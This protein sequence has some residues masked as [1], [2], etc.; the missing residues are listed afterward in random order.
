MERELSRCEQN[1]DY[2][3]LL[4]EIA[5][6]MNVS[7]SQLENYPRDMQMF[8]CQT[9]INNYQLDKEAA[10]LALCNVINL[11]I[12]SEPQNPKKENLLQKTS[13]ERQDKLL[14]A[15]DEWNNEKRTFHISRKQ[16]LHN[17][18]VISDN[19]TNPNRNVQEKIQETEQI[20]KGKNT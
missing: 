13:Q 11:N 2:D 12:P 6:L 1:S 5:E 4:P 3:R 9:Y 18:K 17:A 10:K 7:V 14:P 19:Y 8:L 16:I 20:T 15:C